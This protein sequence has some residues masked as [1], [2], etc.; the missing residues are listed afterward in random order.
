[1]LIET[2]I[3]AAFVV[4]FSYI[5]SQYNILVKYYFDL[6]SEIKKPPREERSKQTDSSIRK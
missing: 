3:F 5:L 2:V 4:G 6:F 1:M